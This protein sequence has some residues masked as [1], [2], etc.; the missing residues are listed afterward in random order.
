LITINA[1]AAI[2]RRPTFPSMIWINP[3][4]AYRDHLTPNLPFLVATI[5]RRGADAFG[6]RGEP[7]MLILSGQA[8]GMEVAMAHKLIPSDC[9]EGVPVY[10]GKAERIGTIER[11]MIDKLTGNIAY[12]VIKSGGLLGRHH[13]P[14]PWDSLKYNSSRQAY[15]TGLTLDEL[16]RGRS[17]QDGEFDWGNR[18]QA[19]Q[20]PQYWTL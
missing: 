20:H 3:G 15:E 14:L 6:R 16:R 12:T 19:Y 8:K 9:V 5:D 10:G 17:E 1:A 2:G 18:A 7:E 4:R 11:L 13:Y